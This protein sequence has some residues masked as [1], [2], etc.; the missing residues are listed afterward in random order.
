MNHRSLRSSATAYTTLLI[1]IGFLF[2]LHHR[3][4]IFLLSFNSNFGY[5]KGFVYP[6]LFKITTQLILLNLT[7]ETLP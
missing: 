6:K 4:F 1:M 2:R 5:L 7:F 3:E